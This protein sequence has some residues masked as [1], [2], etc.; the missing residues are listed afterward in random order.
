MRP[1]PCK[2][3]YGMAP[4]IWVPPP[5]S[6]DTGGKRTAGELNTRHLNRFKSKGFE[7]VHEMAISRQQSRQLR[8]ADSRWNYLQVTLL[9]SSQ[10]AILAVRRTSA[11][12]RSMT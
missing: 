6:P 12:A 2:A 3:V 11:N 5:Q 1:S 10:G 4:M 8:I 7:V 9:A